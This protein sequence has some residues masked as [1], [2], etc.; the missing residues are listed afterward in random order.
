MTKPNG[1][2]AGSERKIEK[3]QDIVVKD[4]EAEL[5]GNSLTSALWPLSQWE[6]EGGGWEMSCPLAEVI[7]LI[8]LWV[9]FVIIIFG[10]L[11]CALWENEQWEIMFSHI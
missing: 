4:G 7:P 11:I 5:R 1:D 2:K 3:H 8:L 10:F 9:L 6:E